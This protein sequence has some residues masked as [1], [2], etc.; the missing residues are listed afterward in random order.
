MFIQGTKYHIFSFSYSYGD[1]V[2]KIFLMRNKQKLLGETSRK[3][4]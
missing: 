4:P 1:H 3:N 2:T